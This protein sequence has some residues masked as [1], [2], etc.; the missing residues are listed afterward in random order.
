[1]KLFAALIASALSLG[2]SA[3]ATPAPEYVQ[4]PQKVLPPPP[5]EV[6]VPRPANFREVLLNFLS[7]KPI[8]QTK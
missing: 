1:M 8:G 2:I 6:M 4:P 7:V 5:A 3:C